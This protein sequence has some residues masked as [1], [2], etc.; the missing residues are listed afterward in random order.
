MTM[1]SDNDVINEAFSDSVEIAQSA[2][3]LAADRC[4]DLH[5]SPV[6]CYLIMIELLEINA[7]ETDKSLHAGAPD[8]VSE[9]FKNFRPQ[10]EKQLGV[11]LEH[12]LDLQLALVI[13]FIKPSPV[14]KIGV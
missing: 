14:K 11:S 9:G 12:P 3:K 10:L 5:I 13:L 8:W 7:A 4:I 6:F 1:I 2:V